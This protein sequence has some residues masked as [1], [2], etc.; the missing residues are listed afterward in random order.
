MNYSLKPLEKSRVRLFANSGEAVVFWLALAGILFLA[1]ISVYRGYHLQKIIDQYNNVAFEINPLI[2]NVQR[3][4]AI[5]DSLK[6][7]Q[8]TLKTK[9]DSVKTKTIYLDNE[10]N[11][12]KK[13][14]RVNPKPGRQVIYLPLE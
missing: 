2:L 5:N 7:E 8:E 9:L 10:L 1:I 12:L 4:V 13:K 3:V 6:N 11:K 14:E